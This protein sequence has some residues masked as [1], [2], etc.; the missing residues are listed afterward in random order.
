MKKILIA[1]LLVC[2]AA[3]F[4]FAEDMMVGNGYFIDEQGMAGALWDAPAP[5]PVIELI[6]IIEESKTAN[7]YYSI[8]YESFIDTVQYEEYSDEYGDVGTIEFFTNNLGTVRFHMSTD[9]EV[10][11][12]DLWA[13][14]AS[15][16][17][18]TEMG[19]LTYIGIVATEYL[20]Q[21]EE[22]AEAFREF[23]ADLK[24]D[25]ESELDGGY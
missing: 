2:G 8:D 10:N 22:G 15:Y 1:V 9:A 20:Q 21:E 23:V 7:I 17:I 24:E 4:T 3:G 13:V 14:L 16:I 5:I 25:Y 19:R 12:D 18:D 6:E 11:A